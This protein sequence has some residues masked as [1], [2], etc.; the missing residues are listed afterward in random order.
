MKR[1]FGL[2]SSQWLV[3]PLWPTPSRS[4]VDHD[5]LHFQRRSVAP[6]LP[7]SLNDDGYPGPDPVE[8]IGADLGQPW[9]F[10][11]RLIALVPVE[12]PKTIEFH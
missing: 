1:S 7:G 4:T 11:W 8:G 5:R 3:V 2:R 10:Q 6:E 9:P 12:L